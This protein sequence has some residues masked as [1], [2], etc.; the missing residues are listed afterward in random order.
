MVVQTGITCIFA[1]S[2]IIKEKNMRLKKF[3][4]PCAIGIV[5]V[6]FTCSCKDEE[7]EPDSSEPAETLDGFIFGLG[8]PIQPNVGGNEQIGDVLT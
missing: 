3:L 4:S 7:V 6:L 1:K 2:K 5:A 8:D